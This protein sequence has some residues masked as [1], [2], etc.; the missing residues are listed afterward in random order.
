METEVTAAQIC[1]VGALGEVVET[2]AV[3]VAVAGSEVVTEAATE[4]VTVAASE[5]VTV[6]AS[7]VTVAGAGA[8]SEVV[9]DQES[10]AGKPFHCLYLITELSIALQRVRSDPSGQHR[11]T[12][13]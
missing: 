9:V 11:C 7:E 13:V 2:E 10:R 8:A 5:A 4:A 1:E 12:P 6:A 3:A